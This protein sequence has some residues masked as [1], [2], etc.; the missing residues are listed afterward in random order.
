MAKKITMAKGIPAW[1][2]G[3]LRA[4]P[5]ARRLVHW[6]IKGRDVRIASGIGTG[7][8]LNA[9]ASNPAY[10]LGTNEL[11]VQQVLS[12]HL[13]VGSVFY[14]IGANIGFFSV[15]AAR[16]VGMQGQVYA[17]EPL[18]ENADAIRRNI[19]LNAFDNI[20][21]IEA[22]VA[23]RAGAAEFMV[24]HYSGGSSLAAA[25]IPPD[26]KEI[27]TVEMV[28]LDDL[29]EQGRILPPHVV[30]IDVEGAELQV[31]KGMPQIL[32]H[33][34]PV[35]VYEIDDHD[36]ASFQAKQAACESC[37]RAYG[38]TIVQL[39]ESYPGIEWRVGNYLALPP[40]R[41]PLNSEN[42]P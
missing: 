11:P 3:R 21:V 2:R 22:A 1:L 15:L 25:S 4:L 35:I 9:A 36:L 42:Y 28:A 14:D 39:D 40:A 27:I 37:L 38:Y 31:L 8:K 16:L 7:L 29:L 12:Q 32:S 23:E 17:F 41:E 33:H 19:K 13:A 30:K 24:S 6:W 5:G 34:C 18:P 26:L 10:A 20:Q